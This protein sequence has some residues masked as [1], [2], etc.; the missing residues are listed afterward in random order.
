MDP[1][2]HDGMPSSWMQK[3]AYKTCSVETRCLAASLWH[4]RRRRASNPSLV[5]VDSTPALTQLARACTHTRARTHARIHT[6]LGACNVGMLD[7]REGL[8]WRRPAT[9]RCVMPAPHRLLASHALPPPRPPAAASAGRLR[10]TRRRERRHDWRPAGPCAP[11]GALMANS[12]TT[13]CAQLYACS[14]PELDQL[15]AIARD[16]GA[17]GARLTGGAGRPLSRPLLAH[18]S[19]VQGQGQH[20][21]I[22]AGRRLCGEP[23][24]HRHGQQHPG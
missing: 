2:S 7:E 16:A 21:T 6:Q 14:C 11:L 18:L 3:L 23:T 22:G 1:D 9:K 20:H 17:L 12:N 4:P 8:M 24:S 19:H 10:T 5:M 15:V 13:S